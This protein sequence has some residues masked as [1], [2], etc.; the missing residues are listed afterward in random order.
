VER[1]EFLRFFRCHLFVRCDEVGCARLHIYTLLCILYFSVFSLPI[2]LTSINPCYQ[3]GSSHSKIPWELISIENKLC[4]ARFTR[5]PDPANMVNS[6]RL[7]L[8]LISFL[9]VV[10]AW[11]INNN[12]DR[13]SCQDPDRELL[14]GC[15]KQKTIFVDSVN[16]AAQFKT[17]QSGGL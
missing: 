9:S 1:W 15:D 14:E 4:R 16:P 10:S 3:H 6:S 2:G 11:D 17:I 12:G 13:W 8:L 5:A 7:V